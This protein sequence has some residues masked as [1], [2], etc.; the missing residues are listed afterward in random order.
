M[1]RIGKRNLD[2]SLSYCVP[3]RLVRRAMNESTSRGSLPKWP[4]LCSECGRSVFQTTGTDLPHLTE[5][6]RLC[7]MGFLQRKTAKQIGVELG[8][9]HHAVEQHLKAARK[10]LGARDTGEAARLFYGSPHTMVEPYYGAT[11]L[12][13]T[14]STEA[15]DTQPERTASVLRDIATDGPRMLQSLTAMQTLVAIGICGLGVIAIL[16]LIIAVAN[17]V[18]QLTP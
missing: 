10:K 15:S 17:G 2:I 8:I 6:Q 5:R 12:P 7:L 14:A 13:L 18:A 16:S 3:H 1:A 9:S 11:E 4:N